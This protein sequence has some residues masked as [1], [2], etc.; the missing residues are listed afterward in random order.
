MI[1]GQEPENPYDASI[2]WPTTRQAT[3]TAPTT[4]LLMQDLL[5]ILFIICPGSCSSR[6]PEGSI[7]CQSHFSSLLHYTPSIQKLRLPPTRN[8][9]SARQSLSSRSASG[10]D[11]QV[12]SLIPEKI[13]FVYPVLHTLPRDNQGTK[14]NIPCRKPCPEFNHRC[15]SMQ[16]WFL[17]VSKWD[18][19]CRSPVH[20]TPIQW[21]HDSFLSFFSLCLNK[22][23]ISQHK[24]S[25]LQLFDILDVG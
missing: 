14:V 16:A 15:V 18:G 24:L 11:C 8:M 3:D 9:S 6:V 10:K 21:L 20:F 25:R 19:W 7:N 13:F 4:T 1:D 2:L 12:Q 23:Q 17:E 22:V 5:L